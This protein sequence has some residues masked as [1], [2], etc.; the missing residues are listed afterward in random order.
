M[1]NEHQR[2]AR[3]TMAQTGIALIEY[4][5]GRWADD[6]DPTLPE[7]LAEL[8]DV[9]AAHADAIAIANRWRV[10]ERDLLDIIAHRYEPADEA[11]NGRA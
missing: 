9:S 2:K 5:L 10:V 11:N 6:K 7:L 3:G 1:I 8:A 4:Q